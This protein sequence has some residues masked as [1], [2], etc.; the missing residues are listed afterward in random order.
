[1]KQMQELIFLRTLSIEYPG[2]FRPKGEN[3]P[4]GWVGLYLV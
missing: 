2:H 3:A 1:M 4:G